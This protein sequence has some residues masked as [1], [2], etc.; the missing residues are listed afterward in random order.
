[1]LPLG[2]ILYDSLEILP[3]AAKGKNKTRFYSY[4]QQ[5]PGDPA[6][7][8][9]IK[10]YRM[11]D[12]LYDLPP[13]EIHLL[14]CVPTGAGLGGGSADGAQ[15]LQILNELFKLKLPVQRLEKLA[16]RLGSDCPFFVRN[17]PALVTGRGEK[18]HPVKIH[19]SLDNK[20]LVL[21]N[22]GIHI[23]TPLAYSMVRPGKP[24]HSLSTSIA[25]PI[26]T[27][28]RTI[29]NDFER[30]VFARFPSIGEL[31]NKMYRMGALYAAMSGSGSTVYG[32]FD[33]PKEL[34]K[35][36]KGMRVWGGPISLGLQD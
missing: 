10:A 1:M 7:N 9:C 3:M 27:W 31:K 13:V 34:N 18:I 15:A 4:G 5:I 6:Q 35:A 26:T 33:G 29:V 14:K 30:S 17:T 36:F 22:P 32:I 23:S 21:I 25:Q 12:E 20:F 19:Q 8:L 24:E 28:K 2:K 11:L 16:A